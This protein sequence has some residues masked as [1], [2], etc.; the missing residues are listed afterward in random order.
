MADEKIT[1][2]A[3]ERLRNMTHTMFCN[4]SVQAKIDILSLLAS[5]RTQEIALEIAAEETDDRDKAQ[6][7]RDWK[8]VAEA[9]AQEGK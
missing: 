6:T 7:I 8:R 4:I 9:R 5:Y 3:L 1:P 2:E